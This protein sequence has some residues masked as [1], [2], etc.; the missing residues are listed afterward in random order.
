M[1]AKYKVALAL[2]AGFTLGAGAIQAL[3]AQAKP[4]YVI[5]MINVKDEEGYKSNFLGGAK[6]DRRSWRQV[7]CR[8]LQQD[9][10]VHWLAA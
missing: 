1:Q 10:G 2:T 3:H 9:D 6:A 7:R 5:G 8:W 4:S